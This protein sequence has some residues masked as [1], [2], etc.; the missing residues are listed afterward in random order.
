MKEW[1]AILIDDLKFLGA[2]FKREFSDLEITP[3]TTEQRRRRRDEMERLS[4]SGKLRRG[5]LKIRDGKMTFCGM[6]RDR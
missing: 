6:S 5:V 1:F 4:I 3:M 2:Q